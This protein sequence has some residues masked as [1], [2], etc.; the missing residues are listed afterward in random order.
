LALIF[1]VFI[2]IRI[3]HWRLIFNGV[4]MIIMINAALILNHYVSLA[5]AAIH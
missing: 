5:S 2:K 1:A 3:Q 4:V